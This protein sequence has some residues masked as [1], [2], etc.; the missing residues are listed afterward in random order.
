ME[1]WICYYLLEFFACCF[2]NYNKQKIDYFQE[3]QIVDDKREFACYFQ[4]N[5]F[6]L[7]VCYFTYFDETQNVM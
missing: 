5:G 2:D 3:Y 1:L 4:N 7:W 6:Q